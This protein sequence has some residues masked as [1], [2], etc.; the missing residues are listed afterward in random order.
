L[1][2]VSFKVLG[3]FA[4]LAAPVVVPLAVV[5]AVTS[6]INN[7]MNESAE[8]KGAAR[9]TATSKEQGGAQ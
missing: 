6:G 1:V 7:S 4:I 3:P 5:V 2:G 8:R 9:E